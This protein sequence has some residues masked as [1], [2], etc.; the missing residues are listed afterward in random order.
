M[1]RDW[2]GV[3]DRSLHD[4]QILTARFKKVLEDERQL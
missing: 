1:D 4:L 2:R 3:T